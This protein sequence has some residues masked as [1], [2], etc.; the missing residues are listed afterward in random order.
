MLSDIAQ[1]IFF[2]FL[3]LMFNIEIDIFC[4]FFLRGMLFSL[5]YKA[6]VFDYIS[7]LFA[8]MSLCER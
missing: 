6:R 2:N 7:V 3:F 5:I 1:N 4:V 8:V